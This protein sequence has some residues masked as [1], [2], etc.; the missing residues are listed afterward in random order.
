MVVVGHNT[1]GSFSSRN[2]AKSCNVVLVGYGT[3]P[4]FR[5]L[6]VYHRPTVFSPMYWIVT[7]MKIVSLVLLERQMHGFMSSSPL[8][9]CLLLLDETATSA[10]IG[11]WEADH[12][13]DVLALF[14]FIATIAWR[15]NSP[16]LGYQVPAYSNPIFMIDLFT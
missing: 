3:I 9:G 12:S 14:R 5:G 2:D 10:K 11:M 4:P 13:R 1:I 8:P 7:R 15:T 6:R 16:T